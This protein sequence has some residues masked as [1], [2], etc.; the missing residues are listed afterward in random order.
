[1]TTTETTTITTTTTTSIRQVNPQI[2]TFTQPFSRNGL[3]KIGLRGTVI[4]LRTN[5][6]FVIN[7]VSADQDGEAIKRKLDELGTVK[8]I[9]CPDLK[10]HLFAKQY[11][12]WYPNAQV[13][14]MEGLPEKKK[15]L[16]FDIVYGQNFNTQK[17]GFEDE[18]DSVYFSG[19]VN[20]DVAFFHRPTKT[21]IVADL[22][23]NLP[24]N[25]AFSKTDTSP[26]SGLLSKFASD[27]MNPWSSW[28]RGFLKFAGLGHQSEMR[29]DAQKVLDWDFERILMCHGDPIETNAKDAWRSAY[30]S[31]LE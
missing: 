27:R 9:A 13:I 12:D 3:I 10:H 23:W 4:K 11:K 8:W 30:K 20:K 16:H 26:K 15:D 14:G 31:Y 22:L 19:F 29:R 6:L 17:W 5:D 21:L 24:A 28:H 18:I 1:M 2:W 7:P 25:E